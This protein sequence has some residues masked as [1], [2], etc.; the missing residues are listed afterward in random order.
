MF[1]VLS[2]TIDF[3]SR[4]GDRRKGPPDMAAD[5]RPRA[6]TSWTLPRLW[7]SVSTR[8]GFWRKSRGG[9][10]LSIPWS[11]RASLCRQP[12]LGLLSSAPC[13]PPLWASAPCSALPAGSCLSSDLGPAICSV[14][15]ALPEVQRSPAFEGSLALFHCEQCVFELII[16]WSGSRSVKPLFKIII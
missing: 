11:P 5:P 2:P 10:D 12:G 13:P 14:A 4:E 1:V 7:F 15:S 9:T 16:P 8:G 6:C 3:G